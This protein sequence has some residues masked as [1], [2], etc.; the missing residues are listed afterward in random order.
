VELAAVEPGSKVLEIGAGLGSLTSALASAGGEVVAV[1]RDRAL[2]P[3]LEEVLSGSRSV[4]IVHADALTADWKSL[5]EDG[6]WTVVANLPYNVSVPVV[7]RLLE[8]EP[9]V[10][11]MLVMIQREVGER[12][13]ASP[14]G[15]EYG[16]VSIRVAYRAEARLVRRVSRSV[17][18]P[19]PNVDSV[20]VSLLRRAVPPVSVAEETLW[21][22]VD[23]SFAQRRKNMRGAMMRIGLTSE[24]AEAALEACGVPTSRR[25]EQLGLAE[26]GCLAEQCLRL[27]AGRPAVS[28]P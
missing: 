24:E 11:R 8:E 5:L 6:E 27:R 3:A 26:F 15:R 16:R 17:F 19:V 23:G 28:P 1:E 14:G 13:A 12:L 4:R 10:Q 25:P 21:A 2:I 9:R 20:M 22:V 7:M 18:W